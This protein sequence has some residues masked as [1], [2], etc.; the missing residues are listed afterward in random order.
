MENDAEKQLEEL[1]HRELRQ[2]PNL[3]APDALIRRVRSSIAAQARP[4]WWQRPIMTWP[5]GFRVAFIALLVGS[6]GLA[7][8]SGA[9]ISL[10]V[11]FVFQKIMQWFVTFTPLREHLAALANAI[12][13]LS[14]AISTHFLVYAASLLG[15]MYLTCAGFGTLLY[16]VA[17]AKR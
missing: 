3:P 13:V 16:R 10:A 12:S 11:S 1:I 6:L 15:L 7:A 4:P 17:M 9:E 8:F 14:R 2:L 5:L